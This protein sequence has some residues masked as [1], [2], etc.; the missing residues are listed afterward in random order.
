MKH[1]KEPWRSIVTTTGIRHIMSKHD[2]VIA[3]IN[4]LADG[5][6]NEARH[7]EADHNAK[8]IAAAPE[9]L[10]ANSAV[11]NQMYNSRKNKDG[12]YDI[13]IPAEMAE[14]IKAAISKATT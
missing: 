13:H 10:E 4:T 2:Q 11:E 6:D 7:K 8:L 12:S 5:I 9:L 1:S 14:S 3:D